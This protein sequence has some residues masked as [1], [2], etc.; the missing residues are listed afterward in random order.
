MV[1]QITNLN[2]LRID[3]SSNMHLKERTQRQSNNIGQQAYENRM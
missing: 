2:Y 3:L 1:E